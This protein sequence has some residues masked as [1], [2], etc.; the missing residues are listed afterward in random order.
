MTLKLYVKLN[1][2]F[3]N[4]CMVIY[5]FQLLFVD[6]KNKMIYSTVDE[7]KTYKTAKVDFVPNK[8]VFHP[9]M[10]KWVLAYSQTDRTVSKI[11]L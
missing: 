7:G 1:K 3:L 6:K 11:E 8:L 10:P 5:L 4:V 2:V 9:T